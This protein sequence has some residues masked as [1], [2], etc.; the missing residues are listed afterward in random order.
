MTRRTAALA[1]ACATLLFIP[2]G[3]SAQQAV[4]IKAGFSPYTLDAPTAVTLAFRI[5]A[6]GGGL[7]SPVT[8]VQFHYPRSLGLVR[9]ELGLAH[10]E[11]SRLRLKGPKACP[12]N[13]IMGRGEALAELQV[14]PEI[15]EEHAKVALV[16][17]PSPDGYLHLLLSATGGYPVTARVVMPTLLLPG[18]L[19]IAVP[20]VHGLPEGPDVALASVRLT[21]GGRLTYYVRR[22]GRRVAY[23]P[24][25]IFLPKR[26]PRG[27]FRFGA[28]FHFLD[29]TAAR[30][31]TTVKCP[32]ARALTRAR[33]RRGGAFL[34]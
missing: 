2:A 15:P 3:A 16:A 17:G 29:G 10:C 22:H 24:K 1:A 6:I 21:I 4:A 8:N 33:P 9:S 14:G 34:R 11:P 7:P 30:A 31:Q 13:S 28:T 23:H 20:L 18:K 12:A 27:G 19:N 26:C 25:G 5:A 32:R